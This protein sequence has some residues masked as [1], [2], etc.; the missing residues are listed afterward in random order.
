VAILAEQPEKN[1]FEEAQ[2]KIY[3]LR[4]ENWQNF[5]LGARTLGIFAVRYGVRYFAFSS[6]RINLRAR[7][8]TLTSRARLIG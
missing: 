4:W 5:S 3:V 8:L 6:I 1:V 7:G 2:G